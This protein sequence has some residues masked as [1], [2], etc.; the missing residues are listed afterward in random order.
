MLN[1]LA[2]PP[3]TIAQQLRHS[4]GGRLVVQTYGH[5]DRAMH[6]SRIAQAEADGAFVGQGEP[7]DTELR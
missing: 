3:Y 1:E 6:L 4:D 7:G 5:P 2:L